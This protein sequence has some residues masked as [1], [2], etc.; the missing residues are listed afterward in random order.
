MESLQ[1]NDIRDYETKLCG[2]PRKSDLPIKQKSSM[3]NTIDRIN[4]HSVTNQIKT[5]V[6]DETEFCMHTVNTSWIEP[7]KTLESRYCDMIKKMNGQ[8]IECSISNI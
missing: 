7:I 8:F 1:L 4:K 3:S 5:R 2:N 6:M